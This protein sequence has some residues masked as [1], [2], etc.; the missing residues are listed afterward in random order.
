[1]DPIEQMLFD[2]IKNVNIT[3]YPVVGSCLSQRYLG[4][5]TWETLLR[6]FAQTI[7]NNDYVLLKRLF[8]MQLSI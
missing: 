7:R 1:M 6:K 5:E 8:R 3:P 2:L 4:A